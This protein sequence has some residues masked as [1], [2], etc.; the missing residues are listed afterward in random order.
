[1]AANAIY[2]P[3]INVPPDPWLLRMLLYWDRL[4]AIVPMEYHYNPRLL[5]PKMRDMVAAGLVNPIAPGLYLGGIDGFATPFLRFAERWSHAHLPERKLPQTRIHAEKLDGLVKPLL[6]MGLARRADGAWYDMPTPVANCL[7]AHLAG[8]LGQVDQIDAAP[9]TASTSLGQ[10]LWRTSLAAK[11]DALLEILFPMPD[12]A[13]RLTLDDIV[14]FKARHQPL[15]ARFRERVQEECTLL[16]DAVTNEERQDRME[17]LGRKLQV[18]VNE[19]TEAMRGRWTRLIFGKVL[20]VLAPAIP[21]VDA[22]FPAQAATFLGAAV[23]GG[24]AS[25]QSRLMQATDSAVRRR[26]L[27]YVALARKE[28]ATFRPRTPV[29]GSGRAR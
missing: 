26:P 10:S 3:Y 17:A 5:E 29:A 2:F 13:E 14:E 27:A 11:R 1:V 23:S 21:L 19:I 22:V 15:A 25:Y 7:M 28:L 18:E 9:V 4:S 6:K 12:G 24:L 20:P 8:A 16:P